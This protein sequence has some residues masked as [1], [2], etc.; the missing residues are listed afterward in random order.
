MGLVARKGFGADNEKGKHCLARHLSKVKAFQVRVCV[1]TGGGS[2][3]QQWKMDLHCRFGE[4]KEIW[5]HQGSQ[6]H[7]L[8][9]P[10]P[11]SQHS[12]LP[13]GGLIW[14]GRL[15][16]AGNPGFSRVLPFLQLS[17]QATGDG[18]HYQNC[19]EFSSFALNCYLTDLPTDLSINGSLPPFVKSVPQSLQLLFSSSLPNTCLIAAV[20]VTLSTCISSQFSTGNGLSNQQARD[21]PCLPPVMW[22]F[23]P[24]CSLVIQLEDPI[25][26]IASQNRMPYQLLDWI[27]GS[28]T[29]CGISC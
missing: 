18:G 14:S 3:F 7:L 8:R 17:L 10:H 26:S 1:C 20:H 6:V 21:Q 24:S 2:I 13:H 11:S 23:F 9:Q 12:L 19:K 25:S 28:G 27:P 16:F 15:A 22:F 29:W 4:F 5:G